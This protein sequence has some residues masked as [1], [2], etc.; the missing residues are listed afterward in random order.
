M[1]KKGYKRRPKR[2]PKTTLGLVL[3]LIITV[4]TT[5]GW[6]PI[7][8]LPDELQAYLPRQEQTYKKLTVKAARHPDEQLAASVL[9]PAVRAQL[10]S[11]RITF[12]G[13]GAWLINHNQT[14]LQAN[15]S[16]A[17]YVHLAPLDDLGRPGVA[18]ALLNRTSRQY[19]NRQETGMDRKIEP[20]GWHQVNLSGP[21]QVLYNR[22]HSIGYALAG[23]IT[24]FD[25]SEA[26]RQNITTQTAWANQASN[27]D[28]QNTGQNYYETLVRRAQDQ[29]KLVRYR[30]TPVYDGS[31]LLPAGNHLEAKSRD[32]SLEFNVFIPNVQPGITINYQTGQASP[33][34]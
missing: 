26:N 14:D 10:H 6:I 25:A 28:D 19:R 17:P 30:V 34:K 18:N 24:S 3:V 22:G 21:Y 20:L 9:T 27:G 2:R 33:M 12:N 11:Q 1:G 5:A 31:A 8:H 7:Q 13:A 4:A 32:D 16:T 15:V 23:R 29:N